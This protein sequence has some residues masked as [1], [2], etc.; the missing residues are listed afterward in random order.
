M[1]NPRSDE[2]Q[3]YKTLL[4]YLFTIFQEIFMGE[5]DNL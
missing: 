1:V 4:S 3:S 5:K 2:V